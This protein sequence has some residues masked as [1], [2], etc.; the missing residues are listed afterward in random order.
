LAGLAFQRELSQKSLEID[1]SQVGSRC[2]Q[3]DK[4]HKN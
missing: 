2:Y 3:N 1:S 4:K